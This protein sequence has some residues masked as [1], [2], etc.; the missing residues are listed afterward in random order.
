MSHAGAAGSECAPRLVKI[1]GGGAGK[2]DG[3]EG[4]RRVVP[5]FLEHRDPPRHR[6]DLVDEPQARLITPCAGQVAALG[7]GSTEV[8]GTETVDT[9]VGNRRRPPRRVHAGSSRESLDH[10]GLSHPPRTPQHPQ[11]TGPEV[12]E[13][14]R[15]VVDTHGC[16]SAEH[17]IPAGPGHRIASGRGQPPPG[18]PL[19]EEPAELVVS[20]NS[21]LHIN[22]LVNVDYQPSNPWLSVAVGRRLR[23]R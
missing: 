20:H 6:G 12:V 18:I 23:T 17:R 14:D 15:V 1:F 7:K 3:I 5:E 2:H 16:R 9:Q 19:P 13:N 21:T 22:P 8:L 11:S 10:H 4:Q